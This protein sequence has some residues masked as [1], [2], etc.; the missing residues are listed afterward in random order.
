VAALEQSRPQEARR[1]F[2]DS[3][4]VAHELGFGQPLWWCF[5]SIAALADSP[6]AAARLLGTAD[7]LRDESRGRRYVEALHD[8]TSRSLRSELGDDL[9]DQL[10]A[11]GR[12]TPIDQAVAAALESVG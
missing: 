10:W 1:H 4:L 9:F 11:E 5:D 12:D 6:E 7:R 2:R 8:R 3:L